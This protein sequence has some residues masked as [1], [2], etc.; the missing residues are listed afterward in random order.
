M[1]LSTAALES[2][3]PWLLFTGAVLALLALDLLVFHRKAHEVS[4]REA[5]V[6]SVFWIALAL[7]FNAGVYWQRGAEIGLQWTT[8]YLIEYS[9]SIDNLFVFLLTFQALKIPPVYQHRL[10]FWGVLGALVMRAA[11]IGVGGVLIE[12]FHAVLYVFGAILIVTAIKLW[13]DEQHVPSADGSRLIRFVRRFVP[14][15]DSFEGQKFFVR[16]AGVLY[17]TPLFVAL[18][19]IEGADLVF[20][21]DSVP[22]IFAVTSDPFIVFTAA[23]SALLGLRSLY[24]VL[25]GY[26]AGLVYLRLALMLILLFVGMKLLLVDLVHIP[27]LLSLGVIVGILGVAALASVWAKP[28]PAHATVTKAAEPEEASH[29]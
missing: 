21:V 12:Q 14:V 11:L 1:P 17:M 10:L 13:R 3:W 4:R 28:K 20:A 23:I 19:L 26:I 24:F 9:L 5:L 2:L 29:R 25:S 22:A 7:T 27:A 6:W 15:T 8:G 18:L 16:R